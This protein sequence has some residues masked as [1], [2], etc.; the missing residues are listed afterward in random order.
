MKAKTR[1]LL[2]A[3]AAILLTV[4][5]QPALA[6][7]TTIG[8]ATNVVT[9]GNVR[10]KLHEKTADGSDFPE[11]GV[12]V[13]PGDLVSKRVSVEN[14]CD[15]PFYLRVRLVSGTTNEALTPEDAMRIDM[16]SHILPKADHGSDSL[17]CSIKQ[18]EKAKSKGE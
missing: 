5:T 17:E 2:I 18:V 12:Y 6:F 13:I 15:H 16:H 1:L 8:K 14:V 4:L 9:S 3:M 10:L 11:E 7:Y